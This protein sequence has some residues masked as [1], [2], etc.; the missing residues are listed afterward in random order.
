[1][2]CLQFAV[3]TFIEIMDLSYLLT[4][5]VLSQY[6]LDMFLRSTAF[7]GVVA[8]CLIGFS[9]IVPFQGIKKRAI[10][11]AVFIIDLPFLDVPLRSPV[12]FGELLVW[13]ELMWLIVVRNASFE[14]CERCETH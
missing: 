2:T 11:L 4:S 12:T 14:K 13:V 10:S 5:V 1:M 3:D 9:S 7:F 6:Y 8:M